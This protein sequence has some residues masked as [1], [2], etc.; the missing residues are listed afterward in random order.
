MTTSN[1]V[2]SARVTLAA[3]FE[4]DNPDLRALITMLGVVDTLHGLKDGSLKMPTVRVELRTTPR[5]ELWDV[6][7]RILNDTDPRR[8]IVTH[9]P[10]RQG[11]LDWKCPV[12]G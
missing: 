11:S 2:R 12:S 10:N 4:P 9:R 7:A 1:D 3:L 5:R 8:R 6:A